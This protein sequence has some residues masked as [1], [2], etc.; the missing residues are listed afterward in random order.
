MY[1]FV[2]QS[3]ALFIVSTFLWCYVNSAKNLI[4]A[5]QGQNLGKLISRDLTPGALYGR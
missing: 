2:N 3:L 1:E 4:K 5:Y